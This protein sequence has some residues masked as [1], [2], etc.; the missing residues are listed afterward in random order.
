M[1]TFENQNSLPSL[2]L[3]PLES[4]LT[5]YY[6][7]LIPLI[8]LQQH[9]K[10]LI[11]QFGDYNVNDYRTEE[12]RSKYKNHKSLLNPQENVIFVSYLNLY[13]K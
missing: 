1:K 6:K 8:E 7:S 12:G 2:P 10:S 4:L 5:T 3:S 11:A 13:R 9:K